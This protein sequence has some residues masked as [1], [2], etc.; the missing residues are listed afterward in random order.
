MD[1]TYNEKELF[2]TMGN[3]I[4]LILT[5]IVLNKFYCQ[6]TRAVLQAGIIL[7]QYFIQ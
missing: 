3:L 6:A 1:D 7:A 4:L 2:S 5:Y